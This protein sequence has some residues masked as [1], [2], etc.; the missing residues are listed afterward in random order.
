MLEVFSIPFM[1]RALLAGL[2]IGAVSSYFGVFVVQRRLAFLGSGLA[3]AAFGGVALALLLQREPLAIAIPFTVMVALGITWVEGNT[4]LAADTVIGIFFSLAMALGIVFL[5]FTPGY[6]TDAFTYLFGS[7]LA[8]TQQDLYAS[9]LLLLVTLCTVPLWGRWAYSTFDREAA[10]VDGRTVR[11]DDYLL[12]V[13]I[14]VSVVVAAK[15]VGIVLLSS[16]LVIPAASARLLAQRFSVMTL[17]SLLCGVL[18]V[19]VGLI[20]SYHYD[21]PSG[22]AVI[23]AQAA[24]FLA[25][26]TA[27]PLLLRARA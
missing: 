27:A 6:S 4:R 15:V 26:F 16:F 23:L 19:A 12:A 5:W 20:A 10:Q 21:L 18:S 3:H 2:L 8:V 25:A 14:A 24:L 17:Q 9:C 22:A 13:L 1:Q 7:L 11:L